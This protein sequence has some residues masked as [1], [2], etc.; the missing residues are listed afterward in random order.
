M[1]LETE[2]LYIE[3]E[4][5]G[6]DKVRENIA[7]QRYGPPNSYKEKLAWEWLRQKDDERLETRIRAQT[8]IAD[9][10]RRAAWISTAAAWIAAIAASLIAVAS[11]YSAFFD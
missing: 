10:S 7:T 1:P 4:A 3:F 6:E 11:I 2:N 8:K 9:S 5:A